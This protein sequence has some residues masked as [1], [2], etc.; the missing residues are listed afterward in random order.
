LLEDARERLDHARSLQEARHLVEGLTMQP[1]G[2][3]HAPA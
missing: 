2:L 1:E 3:C